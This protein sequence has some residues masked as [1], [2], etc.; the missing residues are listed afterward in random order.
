MKRVVVV[1]LMLFHFIGFSQTEKILHGKVVSG[2]TVLSGVDVV[3]AS[4]K[5]SA[6]TNKK[7][8]FSIAVKANDELLIISKEY[9]DKTILVSQKEIDNDNLIIRLEK[10]PIEL[11]EVAVTKSPSIKVKSSQMDLALAK[12]EKQAA[13]PKV[14]GVYDGTIENGMDFVAIGKG[15]VNLV[16]GKD[17]ATQTPPPPGFK[18][19]MLTNFNND[20]FTQ[21]LKLKPEEI[22]LFLAYCEADPK[23]KLIAANEDPLKTTEFVISKNE[24]FKKLQR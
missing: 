19:Y 13:T 3:N 1:I 6:T 10:K 24:E 15:I 9:T 8:L 2:N 17:E 12:L 4:S 7:G 11:K 5:K 14:V 20:F 18:D 21:Q 16:K 22:Q 23:S